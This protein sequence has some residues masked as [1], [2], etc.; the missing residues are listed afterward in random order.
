MTRSFTTATDLKRVLST[1]ITL[2]ELGGTVVMR[3]STLSVVYTDESKKK[4]NIY[5]TGVSSCND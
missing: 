1:F 2:P 5:K 3:D 4:K